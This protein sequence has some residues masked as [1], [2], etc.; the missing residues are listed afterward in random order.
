MILARISSARKVIASLLIVVLYVETVVP[1]HLQA[2]VPYVPLVAEKNSKRN[3]IGSAVPSRVIPMETYAPAPPP[4]AAALSSTK[5]MD[6]GGPTQPEMETFHSAG[7]DNMVNLFS[8]DFNYSIPLIDVGGYPLTLGYNSGVS[9]DQEASWVG[10][11][12]NLNPGAVTRNMR[13]LPDDFNGT[14][15]ITKEIKVEENK[16]VG[17]TAGADVELVGFPE[18]MGGIKAGF[19]LGV[20]KNS[21][22]GW[23]LETATDV[24]IRL[25]SKNSGA[26][27]GGLSLSNSSQGGATMSPSLGYELPGKE[28]KDHSTV[29]GAFSIGTS[30][31]TRSGMR[32]FQLSAGIR[33]YDKVIHKVRD[34]E[35]V[36]QK[37]RF[38]KN[39]SSYISFVSPSYTPSSTI[40]YTSENIAVTLKAG[41]SATVVFPNLFISG[42][43]N[44]QYVAKSDQRFSLPAFGYLNY[45]NGYTNTTA[46]M[47]F[48]RERDITYRDKPA[49]PNIAVPSYTYDVFS[50]SG[51]GTGGTFRGYRNDIG[52]V[53]DAEITTRDNSFHASGDLGIGYLFHGGIDLGASRSYT[54]TGLWEHENPL[55]SVIGFRKTQ[56][57][58][59][60]VYFRNPGEKTINSRS[61]YDGIGGDMVVTAKLNQGTWLSPF[62]STEAKLT[63]YKNASPQADIPMNSNTSAKPAREKRS[64][65]ISFLTAKEASE[66][67]LSKYVENYA[68]NTY[69]DITVHTKNTPVDFVGKGNGL[70]ATYYHFEGYSTKDSL[71]TVIEPDLNFN[72]N[73]DFNRSGMKPALY[74]FFR[75]K[76][77]GRLKVPQSGRYIFKINSDDGF[78]FF[79]NNESI[80][81]D[82]TEHGAY[83]HYDTLYLEGGRLYNLRMLYYN[84][85]SAATLKLSW[86]SE[87]MGP[88]DQFQPIAPEYFFLPDVS[89]TVSTSKIVTMEKRV[90]SYRKE[91]HI[92]EVSVLNGDGK[93]YVYGI[94]VYNLEQK[95]ASFYVDKNGADTTNALVKYT[96]GFNDDISGPDKYYSAEIM[97]SYPHSFL[98]TGILSPDYV[99]VTGNG[100]SDDDIG[101]AIRFNYTKTAGAANPYKW[102]V[103]Y[104]DMATYNAGLRSDYRDD[105]GSYI[106]G[107]KELWYL[108]SVESKNMIAVFLL[109]DRKDQLQI[110]NTGVKSVNGAK[111]LER[112]DLYTKADYRKNGTKATPIKSV[113]FE[114]SYE[115][116]PG[117]NG[118]GYPADSG[119]LTLKRVW[120]SYNG[121]TKGRNNAYVFNYNKLNPHYNSQ[122]YDRW[123][124]YKD[125]AKNPASV[126]GKVIRNEDFPYAIQ[127]STTAA[128]FA[129]AWTLDSIITPA[130]GAMKVNYEADDYAYVQNRRAMQLFQVAGLSMNKPGTDN[131]ISNNLYGIPGGL[132]YKYISINVPIPVTS[133]ADLYNKY[134]EGIGKIYF[135]MY[136]QVPDDG[137]GGGYEPVSCYARL[138]PN[139]GYGFYNGGKTIW[140]KI[141]GIDQM[142]HSFGPSS[143]L[144]VTAFNFM[145]QNLPSKAYPGSDVGADENGAQAAVHLLLNQVSNITELITKFEGQA[146]IR[147][148]AR[149]F[150][151]SRSLVR[152]NNPNYKKYGGGL[153]VKSIISYDHWNKMTGQ[154]ESTYGKEYQYTTTKVVDKD[155]LVISSGVAAYEPMAGG[156]ENPF[157]LPIEYMEEVTPLSPVVMGYTEEPLGETFF[158]A[159]SVGYSKVRVRTINR[160][161]TK[162]ANGFE[163]TCFY[164]A[165]EFPVITER[166]TIN[167]ATKKRFKN[168][169]ADFL[170]VNTLHYLTISQGFKVELNDM[171]G[172]VKSHAVYS[173]SDPNNYITYTENFYRVDNQQLPEKHLNNEVSTI[174]ADGTIN[175]SVIGKDVELMVD[176][177]EQRTL[178]NSGSYGINSDIFTIGIFPATIP[179]LIPL[180]QREENR[181]RSVGITK[182]I[183]RHGILDSVVAIDKGSKVVTHNLLYDEETGDVALTSVQNE[184]NDRVYH[185]S[186][187]AAWIYEGMAGAYK[188]IGTVLEGID[189]TNGKITGGLTGSLADYF[190]SGD[191]ILVYSKKKVFGTEC[192]YKLARWPGAYKAWA[193]DANMLT[194]G[195]PD[196]YFINQDG[197]PLTGHEMTIKIIRSGRRNIAAS[198]GQVIMKGNPMMGDHLVIDQSKQVLNASMVTYNQFWKVPDHKV[199]AVIIDTFYNS[200][201]SQDFTVVC[202]NTSTTVNIKVEAKK[203]WSVV[204]Q[205]VADDLAQVYLRYNGMYLAQQQT[206]C[207]AYYNEKQSDW[208][209][210]LDCGTNGEGSLV[211]VVVPANT[212]S[213]TISVEDANNM[214]RAEV[215]RIGH[216]YANANGKCIFYS[217]PQPGTFYKDDCPDGLTPLAIDYTLPARYDS[218]EYSLADAN[219][220]AKIHLQD[221][222]KEYARMYGKCQFYAKLSIVNFRHRSGQNSTESYTRDS[223]DIRVDF[224][225]DATCTMLYVVPQATIL[226]KATS[227]RSAWQDDQPL[228]TDTYEDPYTFTIS[229]QSGAVLLTNQLLMDD[230]KYRKWEGQPP[231]EVVPT[232]GYTTNTTYTLVPSVEYVIK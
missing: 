44:R 153:R 3:P 84:G 154:R 162:S 33:Q 176:L 61:F 225:K 79:L 211:E 95:E 202:G 22:R 39:H 198:G 109:S 181:F 116:C 125:P 2:A 81:S 216:S 186:Y 28:Q 130:G 34:D 86:K 35:I 106:S 75:A 128:K 182:V 6:D 20:Y 142:G 184:Y 59:E 134:L 155:T 91:N 228:P 158:P 150:D 170:K 197:S 72:N 195:T 93:K 102:R 144:V 31:N 51:E 88:N 183:N 50:I 217:D 189:I 185:F 169:L 157:R 36:S 83:D 98:L 27:T 199:P 14:D 208:Y 121:N 161:K 45:Q 192:D 105:R 107:S 24:N 178:T 156:E 54:R 220:K 222:G 10:L 108:N 57:N 129:A 97:P 205:E 100:I 89:D 124:N 203:F 26:M 123:G 215:A 92:S 165:K 94:P 173:E 55:K 63:P 117:I 212:F 16:T 194:K 230:V 190:F 65:V 66:A 58:F 188:N 17:V 133:N 147:Q 23:G 209:R 7:N 32:G 25:G 64:Q 114:Y 71:Y 12:W 1:L 187:P 180:P 127:D 139:G 160:D 218:S 41:P 120:F 137:Y 146:K 166:T 110:S 52:Y 122:Y 164:T 135:R 101:N 179:S 132:D 145:K 9:M 77:E 148:L 214:A 70:R 113:H 119:K 221:K 42:Y 219:Q 126:P 175:T 48:N 172:Q 206:P 85:P 47:D 112:I 104:N 168:D 103:P 38:S 159:A 18:N 19:S 56:K 73:K 191:E 87:A 171:H 152:L 174:S 74:D 163:E 80:S 210:K 13:G 151:P 43:L 4:P 99:D 5:T 223:G 193:I 149:K 167:D 200:A 232:D 196:I 177:R 30:Y 78:S 140:I 68:L 53:F 37:D 131:D 231:V 118:A 115:L 62:I 229:N 82:M 46:I 213:S 11:G 67:G 60:S 69:P 207:P 21:L 224:Y 90:T 141:Q 136:I 96:P 40:P 227:V 143:P 226:L 201:I 15:S 8:G 29:T 111:K 49:V 204:S 76:Y 138:D